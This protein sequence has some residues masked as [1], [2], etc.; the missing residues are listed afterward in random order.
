MKIE[1]LTHDDLQD[2]KNELLSEIKELLK[3]QPA[4]KKWLKSNEVKEILGCS[5][6]T[7]QNLRING[8][9]EYSRVGGTVYYP[10]DAV[11][12]LLESNKVNHKH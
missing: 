8:T 7:L 5:D 2:F 12:K 10:Y 4:Q 6:G 9:L 1:I 3:S 11:L